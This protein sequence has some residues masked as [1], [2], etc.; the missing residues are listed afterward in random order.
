VKVVLCAP[1]APLPPPN[2][3]NLLLRG[4]LSALRRRHDV[5][6][7]AYRAPWQA[8]RVEQAVLAP[9]PSWGAA[10]AAAELALGLAR[11]EP[12]R[13]R[14]SADGLRA[15]LR[16]AIARH[17]PDVVHLVSGR[18][19]GLA[20]ELGALP[21]VLTAIDAWHLNADAAAAAATGVRRL[22]RSAEA[23]HVRRFE[24]RRFGAFGAVAVITERDRL[25]LLDVAP[26][27][28]VDVVPHGA[29]AGPEPTTARSSSL[30]LMHGVLSYP[31][32]EEAATRLVRCILPKV[33]ATVPEASVALVGRDPTP[34]VT[35]LA[36]VPGVVVTGAVDDVR[37]WLE[38]ATAYVC[39]MASGGG[40]K[41][42]LLEALAAA[43]PCVTT[44]VGASGLAA[45][46]GVEVLVA[47]DDDGIAAHVVALLGDPARAE[48]IGRAGRELVVAEHDW[49]AVGLAYEAIY[50]RVAEGGAGWRGGSCS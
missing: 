9:A 14:R 21:T 22:V 5:L 1:E 12:W 40:I 2:G 35:A 23:R 4:T 37:P 7:V 41:N 36:E 43:A 46:D 16:E 50:E 15:P 31:P 27:L 19:A 20:D 32:N 47:D 39:P 13:A 24:R 45:R 29:D 49:S 26:D 10:T 3:L 48:R 8:G 6:L 38:R 18:L 42:K 17:R 33:R 28:A 34:Q 11:R 30:L 25:A 44:T